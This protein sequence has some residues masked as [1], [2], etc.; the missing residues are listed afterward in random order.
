[1]GNDIDQEA[2]INRFSR[3]TGIK[4][5]KA[6]AEAIGISGKNFSLRKKRGTLLPLFSEWGVKNDIDLNWLLK[7]S[8]GTVINGSYIGNIINNG[9]SG[10]ISKDV[11]LN[12]KTLPTGG[13]SAFNEKL[14]HTQKLAK[15]KEQGL[16]TDAQYQKAMDE[17]WGVVSGTAPTLPSG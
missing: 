13:H 11:S 16:M 17:L 4:I 10:S 2:I 14:D 7:G 12:T 5:E 15:L 1:M 6:I 3:L 9:K 8:G